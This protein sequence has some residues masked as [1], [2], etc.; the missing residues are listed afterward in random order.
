MIK[1]S[2]SPLKSLLLTLSWLFA[3]CFIPAALGQKSEGEDMSHLKQSA[4]D[5]AFSEM[6]SANIMVQWKDGKV[7]VLRDLSELQKVDRPEEVVMV[8]IQ[9]AGLKEIPPVLSRFKNIT[10][11]DLS[12]N[13][14]KCE[15]FSGLTAPRSLRTLYAN[16]NSLDV[17]CQDRLKVRYPKIQF[18]FTIPQLTQKPE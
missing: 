3:L 12:H 15:A 1:K 14:L 8:G 10:L 2:S 13:A 6:P 9:N 11:L 17:A 5:N 16:D 4:K 18:F 7:Q